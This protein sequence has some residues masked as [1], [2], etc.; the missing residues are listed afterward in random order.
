MGCKRE[1]AKVV[2]DAQDLAITIKMAL[3]FGTVYNRCGLIMYV[4]A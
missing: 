2:V 4:C 3:Q 1:I